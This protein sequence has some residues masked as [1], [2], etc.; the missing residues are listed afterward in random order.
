VQIPIF[1]ART[2]AAVALAKSELAEADAAVGSKRQEVRIEVRQKARDVRELDAGREV[3]RLDLKLAQETLAITQ[4]RFEQGQSS[5][6][7]LEQDRLTE[8][9]KWV[10]FL[11]ADFARKQGQ[12]SFL[13]TTGQLAAVFQ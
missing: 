11:N 12:L 2:S 13:Q 9:E 1:A 5:L 4:T 6:R 8:S 3:A 7:E 10:E